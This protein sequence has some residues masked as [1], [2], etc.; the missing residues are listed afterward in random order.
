MED[1][2]T[3]LEKAIMGINQ[4]IKSLSDKIDRSLTFQWEM[5][6]FRKK[7]KAERI[8]RRTLVRNIIPILE[9]LDLEKLD[10]FYTELE[11]FKKGIKYL[12]K[13]V[14]ELEYINYY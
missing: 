11:R 5:S 6:K 14:K 4:E 8:I 2:I 1:K 10:V 9:K 3:L 13:A 12:K 7:R